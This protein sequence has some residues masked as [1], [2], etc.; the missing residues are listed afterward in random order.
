LYSPPIQFPFG[1]VIDDVFPYVMQIGLGRPG[2]IC[3]SYGAKQTDKEKIAHERI[4]FFLDTDFTDYTDFSQ[5]PDETKKAQSAFGR[6]EI[7]NSFIPSCLSLISHGT[8][9]Q[10]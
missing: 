6:K 3:R 5:F 7:E 8:Y 1:R 2:I 4:E 9:A 10:F